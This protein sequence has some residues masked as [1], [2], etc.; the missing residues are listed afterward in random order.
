[1]PG[2]EVYV[3]QRGDIVMCDFNPVAGHEQAHHRPALVLS[4][5]V[6]HERT[7]MAV[8]AP[9]TNTIRGHGLE[10]EIAGRDTTGVAL[11]HQI[12]SIDFEA[13]RATFREQATQA[14]VAEACQKAGLLFK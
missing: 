4:P 8:L 3:P 14:V 10:V 9:I 6:F 7:G 5:R 13:R 1:M 2:S 11:I 12:R